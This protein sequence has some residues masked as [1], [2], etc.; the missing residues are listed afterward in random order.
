[1]TD[2]FGGDAIANLRAHLLPGLWPP[3]VAFAVCA[4]VVPLMIRVSRATG[5]MA[6]PGERHPHMRPTPLLGGVALYAGFAAAV[7]I[8]LPH[9]PET[10]GVL[11]VSGLAAVLLI[12]D[13]RW[14]VRAAIKLVLQLVV[15]LVAILVYGFKITSFG[16]PGDFVVQLG[17][18]TIPITI[19][20]MLGMQNTV[21]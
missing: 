17:W 6:L 2:F 8:F 5:M 16:L 12:A 13:D 19:F 4:V 14:Q 20:W 9:Y 1:M 15:A 7:L 11:V 10:G 18:L 3:L 21:N